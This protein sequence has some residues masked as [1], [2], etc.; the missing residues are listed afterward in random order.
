MSVIKLLSPCPDNVKLKTRHQV[1]VH[2]QDGR[3][4]NHTHLGYMHT[5]THTPPTPL[6]PPVYKFYLVDSWSRAKAQDGLKP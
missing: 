5:H 1:L 3:R 2:L 4:P 6:L